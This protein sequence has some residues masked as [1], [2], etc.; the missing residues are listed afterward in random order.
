MNGQTVN[1]K[2]KKIL[3]NTDF[4]KTLARIS[5]QKGISQ[6]Q[7]NI[8]AESYLQELYAEHDPT[9]N[10]GFIEVFQY[11]IGQ[12]F[13]KNIDTDPS[14]LKALSKLMR[15]HPV[16]FVLTHK[17]YIDLIVLMIVLARHGLPLPFLFA[18]INLDMVGVG[19][20]LRNNGVIFIRRSFKDNAVYKATLRFYVSWL[21]KQQSHFM[22]AIEGTRSRTGKLVWPQMGILKYIAESEQDIN[23]TVKYVP[24]S[25]VYDLIP[26][27]EDMTTEGRG[28]KK[29]PETNL[30]FHL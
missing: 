22:W 27:V 25:I 20:L 12:G 30:S 6:V 7:A 11:L 15:R 14:E 8:E 13:D 4:Q 19:K 1:A 10:F 26:D 18:G 17:S 21:L 24:V 28:K 3:S 9:T 16:A 23:Q 29:K 5:V 2:L